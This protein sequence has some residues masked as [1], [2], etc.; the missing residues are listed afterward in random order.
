MLI[1]INM[2]MY[3][4]VYVCMYIYKYMLKIYINRSKHVGRDRERVGTGGALGKEHRVCRMSAFESSL[5]ARH[6][7]GL[8][9]PCRGVDITGVPRS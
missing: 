7:A 6:A 5:C 3:I 1:Y 8:R 2:Y 4:Y 9:V